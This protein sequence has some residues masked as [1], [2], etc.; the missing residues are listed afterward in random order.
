MVRIKGVWGGIL[1]LLIIVSVCPTKG[2]AQQTEW[3]LAPPWTISNAHASYKRSESS[4]SKAHTATADPRAG[5]GYLYL[6]IDTHTTDLKSR[7]GRAEGAFLLGGS[8]TPPATGTYQFTFFYDYTGEGKVEWRGSAYRF[9]AA[10]GVTAAVGDVRSTTVPLFVQ[11]SHGDELEGVL[12]ALQGVGKIVTGVVSGNLDDILKG[13]VD[14]L[15][16]YKSKSN[17]EPIHGTQQIQVVAALQAGVSYQFY[18]L[19]SGA[20][21]A[22]ASAG[23]NAAE[24]NVKLEGRLRMVHIQRL[25]TGP[26]VAPPP[27]SPPPVTIIITPGPVVT[28]ATGKFTAPLPIPNTMA[29]GRLYACEEPRVPLAN[30]PV[31][32]TVLPPGATSVGEVTGITVSVPGYKPRGA[33]SL[34][35]LT[36]GGMTQVYLGDLCLE[37]EAAAP[38]SV[39]EEAKPD[40]VAWSPRSPLTWADFRASPP[41]D[42]KHRVE[43]AEA[44]LEIRYSYDYVLRYDTLAGKWR[45]RVT[46]VT[47]E[48][49]MDRARSW[50]DTARATEALLNHIQRHFDLQEVYA[51]L[52]QLVL[53]GLEGIGTGREEAERDL[54]R[55]IETRWDAIQA[56]LGAL[57]AQY[58]EET[59]YGSNL[60]AQAYWDGL[61]DRWLVNPTMAPQP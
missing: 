25:T 9:A 44:A 12:G 29:S 40:E 24:A 59:A 27:V 48:N 56:V 4:V 55:K 38:P 35:F 46:T 15:K 14:V 33:V 10:V 1:G 45:A 21:R 43:P 5:T 47:V 17:K 13:V 2:W 11:A 28:D 26:I 53:L 58:D 7:D 18:V 16:G 39:V 32:V 60:A 8:F 6:R 31:T 23:G 42:A 34:F 61:I 51:R 37:K 54:E 22:K 41:P 19:T 49:V 20:V 50:V 57:Q 3:T 52:L 36:I 30:Q